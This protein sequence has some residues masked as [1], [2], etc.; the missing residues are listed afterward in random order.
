M[1]LLLY[2]FLTEQFYGNHIYYTGYYSLYR[3]AL[4]L[5]FKTMHIM[6][7]LEKS[8]NEI[9]FFLYAVYYKLIIS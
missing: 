8:N 1:Y 2:L 5:P 6:A 3:L 7:F 9:R 4:I